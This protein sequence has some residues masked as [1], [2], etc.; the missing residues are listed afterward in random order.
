MDNCERMGLKGLSVTIPHKEAVMGLLT[1]IEPAAHEI[2]AVNTVVFEEDGARK[3]YNTD[4]RAAMDCL[5][6]AI[7]HQSTER[8]PL[9]GKTALLLG[10][11]GVCRAIAWALKDAGAEIIISG[12]SQDRADDLASAFGGSTLPWEKRHDIIPDILINGTPLGMF[13]KLDQSPYDGKRLDPDTIVFET[14]Y[15]PGQTLLVKLARQAECQVI[16]GVDM[17]IRQAEYQYKLFTHTKPPT[18]L[19]QQA[20]ARAINPAQTWDD[21]DIQDDGPEHD[22]RA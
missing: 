16:T 19:M 11:G 22:T 13:P 3:G 12:R 5:L 7:P 10:A 21:S 4:Y 6:E 14:I 8:Q 2:G 17:F 1:E 15:N 18:E 20:L 9:L